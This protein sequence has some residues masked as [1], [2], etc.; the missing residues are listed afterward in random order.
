ML[1]DYLLDKCKVEAQPLEEL[2]TPEVVILGYPAEKQ[3]WLK[4]GD[5]VSVSI[6][7]LGTLT[8]VLR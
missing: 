8:N 2:C 5:E 1:Y 7:Q 4:V 3:E 6:D